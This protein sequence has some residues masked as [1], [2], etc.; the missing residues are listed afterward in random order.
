MGV[1]DVVAFGAVPHS[2]ELSCIFGTLLESALIEPNVICATLRTAHRNH[3][4]ERRVMHFSRRPQHRI[5]WG[6]L[7]ES[8]R[9]YR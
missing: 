1:A 2:L 5:P 4:A 8:C 3:F 9:T 6:M 7:M